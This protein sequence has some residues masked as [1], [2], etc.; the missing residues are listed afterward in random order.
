MNDE[1]MKWSND[2]VRFRG[3]LVMV[4]HNVIQAIFWTEK[5]TWNWSNEWASISHL[6]GFRNKR[7]WLMS[8]TFIITNH[9]MH[10]IYRYLGC[11][12]SNKNCGSLLYDRDRP[13]AVITTASFCCSMEMTLRLTPLHGMHAAFEPL[14][15]LHRIGKKEPFVMR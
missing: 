14:F 2:S 6:V 11:A 4:D 10:R 3:I 12:S 5:S 15:S 1:N 8:L 7:N 13:V 9:D